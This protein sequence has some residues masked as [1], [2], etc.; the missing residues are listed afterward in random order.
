MA[1]L[2][3]VLDWAQAWSEQRV[4]DYLGFYGLAFVPP[5]GLSRQA[6]EAQRRERIGRPSWI[7]LELRELHIVEQQ[8]EQLVVQFTQVYRASN[9]SDRGV[10]RL[11]LVMEDGNWKIAAEKNININQ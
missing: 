2:T 10:K 6:W 4:A 9:Y 1:V 8:S 11:T 3:R 7:K 5:D